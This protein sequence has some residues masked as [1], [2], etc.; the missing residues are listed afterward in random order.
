MKLSKWE[1][2]IMDMMQ[3]YTNLLDERTRIDRE[4]LE[5]PKE[6]AIKLYGTKGCEIKRPDEYDEIDRNMTKL[7]DNLWLS[8]RERCKTKIKGNRITKALKSI[9]ITI[10]V[11][12]NENYTFERWDFD[13]K[14]E[15]KSYQKELILRK[16]QNYSSPNYQHYY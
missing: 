4:W 12:A 6:E 15:N 3:N 11:V 16:S 5:L 9:G 10:S 13:R 14:V 8:V 2:K 7:G 1:Q